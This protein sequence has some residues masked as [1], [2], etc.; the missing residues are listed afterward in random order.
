M[1]RHN[2]CSEGDM[3]TPHPHRA[4]LTCPECG[5]VVQPIVSHNRI[6][7]WYTCSRCGGEWSTRLRGGKPAG[8]WAHNRRTA[9]SPDGERTRPTESPRFVGDGREDLPQLRCRIVGALYS[10]MAELV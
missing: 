5:N 8:A 10:R 9:A 3:D 7:A 4:A 1:S 2:G 6:I